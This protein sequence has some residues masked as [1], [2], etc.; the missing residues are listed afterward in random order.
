MPHDNNR[1]VA[2]R[3]RLVEGVQNVTIPRN[4]RTC[5][6]EDVARSSSADLSSAR[7]VV[8]PLTLTRVSVTAVAS[9]WGD[10]GGRGEEEK[11]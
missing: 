2:W 6:A 9:L 11:R 4:Q 10:T 5:S 7:G 8:I 3:L 1:Q